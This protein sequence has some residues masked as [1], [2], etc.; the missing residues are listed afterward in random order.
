MLDQLTIFELLV[1]RCYMSL[2]DERAILLVVY[3]LSRD[4]I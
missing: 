3:Q 1:S 4:V 2:V